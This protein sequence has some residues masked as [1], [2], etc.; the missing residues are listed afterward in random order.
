MKK[1]RKRGIEYRVHSIEPNLQAA[2]GWHKVSYWVSLWLLEKYDVNPNEDEERILILDQ[3]IHA[4]PFAT[5]G[6]ANIRA[7]QESENTIGLRVADALAVIAGNYISKLTD[8]SRYDPTAPD[9]RVQLPAAW[10]N[11]DEKQFR[12]VQSMCQYF[13]KTGVKYGYLYDTFFDEALIFQSYMSY[14]QDYGNHRY[15]SRVTPEKH[16]AIHDSQL[17]T[18]MRNRSFLASE[19]EE[20]AIEKYGSLRE[21]IKNGTYGPL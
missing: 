4:E 18:L 1:V 3:G 10:F 6:F 13:L 20:N 12:L 5:L 19:C 14:I 16:V 21:A 15:Y 11:L 8:D 9:K 7:E 2:F 17:L